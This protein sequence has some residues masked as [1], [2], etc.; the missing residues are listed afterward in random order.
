MR[1]AFSA[2]CVLVSLA[3]NA[4]PEQVL[5]RAADTARSANYQGVVIYRSGSG[6]ETL[7]LVHGL[8]NGIENERISALSGEPREII[9]Q[10]DSV[11]C[12]LPRDRKIDFKR[13]AIKGLLPGLTAAN[14]KK[15][16]AWYSIAEV[17]MARIAGRMC[18][19][20]E[21]AP[22]DGFRYRYEIWSDEATGIP[23]HVALTTADRQV[24][25]EVMFTEV[26]FPSTLTAEAFQP[27]LDSR[28]FKAVPMPPPASEAAPEQFPLV[29][30]AL[31]PG[32]VATGRERRP[33]RDGVG[34]VDHLMLSDGLSAISV[35]AAQ[36]VPNNRAFAGARQLG[37]VNAYGRMVGDYHVTV[38]GEAP[39]AAIKLV[40]E[41]L[42]VPTSP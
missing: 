17:G 4:S 3:A 22:Q 21:L 29:L 19:G 20:V 18:R 40:A 10:K 5:L 41:Q 13:P 27:Q 2:L 14:M 1:R 32:Y 8:I 6:L 39:M 35:F 23:L 36:G 24:L 16:S 7:K 33:G 15:L 12:L 26:S 28:R 9:R 37:G 42:Q 38:V 30:A 31:P 25:E 11:T 34:Q